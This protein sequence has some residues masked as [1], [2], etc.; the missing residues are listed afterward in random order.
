MNALLLRAFWPV[1]IASLLVFGGCR[2]QAKLD[3]GEIA[4][5]KATHAATL[6]EIAEKTRVAADKAVAA[7]IAY[8]DKALADQAA[9]QKGVNDAYARGNAVGAAVAA[10]TV[11]VREVWRDQCPAT[12]A[13]KGSEPAGRD[14]PITQGRADAIGRIVGYGGQWDATYALAIHRLNQAQTLL[15]ACYEQPGD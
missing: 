13:G 3:A 7:R 1:L 6:A 14:Q 5:L 8:S 2:W 11:R 15:N 9:Y 4:E 12:A 10:G